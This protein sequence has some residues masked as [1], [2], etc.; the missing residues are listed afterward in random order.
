MSL[1][2][3]FTFCRSP[4]TTW[5]CPSV[6]GLVVHYNVPERGRETFLGREHQRGWTD[7]DLTRL[8][9]CLNVYNQ[10]WNTSFSKCFLIS[11]TKVHVSQLMLFV[12]IL[13]IITTYVHGDG[14]T[15][16]LDMKIIIRIWGP[17]NVFWLNTKF[18]NF[19]K[20]LEKSNFCH[21]HHFPYHS[22]RGKNKAIE[23]ESAWKK[24]D[25]WFIPR[26]IR[27]RGEREKKTPTKI[28]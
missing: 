6:K 3:I 22:F 25:T 17:K 21:L 19:C 14:P 23:K 18:W 8:S 24:G 7:V 11:S 1:N 13:I 12:F 4:L 2:T 10:L 16:Y 27:R 28:H 9:W 26:W 5:R 15:V 20:N